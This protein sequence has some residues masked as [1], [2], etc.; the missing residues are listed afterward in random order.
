M[1]TWRKKQ[2]Y[3]ENK[4]SW[5]RNKNFIIF[6]DELKTR[7]RFEAVYYYRTPRKFSFW[8]DWETSTVPQNLTLKRCRFLFYC[9]YIIQIGNMQIIA[10]FFHGLMANKQVA[11]VCICHIPLYCFTTPNRLIPYLLLTIL[12]LL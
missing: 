4:N 1:D 9:F 10:S 12:I 6:N 3:E 8:L 2:D 7:V 5:K 11:R